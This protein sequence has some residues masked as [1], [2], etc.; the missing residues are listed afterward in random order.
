[1]TQIELDEKAVEYLGVL[2]YYILTKKTENISQDL[3]NK[4]VYCIISEQDKVIKMQGENIRNLND[5]IKQ[6]EETV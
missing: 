6:L 4:L 2:G 5:R 1:M 3:V